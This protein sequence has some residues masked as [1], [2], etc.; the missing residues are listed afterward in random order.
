[1]EFAYWAERFVCSW[2]KDISEE[3]DLNLK[4]VPMGPIAEYDLITA[5]MLQFPEK[6]Y[7]NQED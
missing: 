5:L 4:G 3:K 6:C 1:M 7:W 2:Y